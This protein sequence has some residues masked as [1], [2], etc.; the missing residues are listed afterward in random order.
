MGNGMGMLS[1]GITRIE[2]HCKLNYVFENAMD[3]WVD[4]IG[5]R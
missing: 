1:K 3:G 4:V 2:K 5:V